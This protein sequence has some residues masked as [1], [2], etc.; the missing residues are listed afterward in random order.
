V[1]IT[2]PPFTERYPE[3]KGFMDYE[4]GLRLN[5][6]SRNV[7]VRCRNFVNGNWVVDDSF[8]TQE[9]PGFVDYGG[10]DFGLTEDAA[11][12]TQLPDFEP[13]PFARI[14]LYQDAYREGG[15]E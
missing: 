4:G 10:R 5:H 15:E 7:A 13:I 6:A 12:F 2:R 9:D 8:V 1:D 3:L 11:L 14:G